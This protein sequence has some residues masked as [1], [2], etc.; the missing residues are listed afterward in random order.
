MGTDARLIEGWNGKDYERHSSH[1]RQW[2][3]G[4]IAEL[5]LRGDERILDLGC[6]DGSLTRQLDRKSVV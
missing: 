4:L 2:G 3:S 1:Q 6:G 5:T